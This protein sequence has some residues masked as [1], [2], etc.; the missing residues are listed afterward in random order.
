MKSAWEFSRMIRQN[1]DAKQAEEDSIRVYRPL[2][3]A[4]HS[5]RLSDREYHDWYENV[6]W[7]R[8]RRTVSMPALLSNYRFGC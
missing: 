1:L 8:P 3:R 7:P 4:L 6:W 2:R 5:S